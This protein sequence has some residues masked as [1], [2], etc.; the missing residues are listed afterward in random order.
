MQHWPGLRGALQEGKWQPGS[1]PGAA[2]M[3][4][5]SAAHRGIRG[6]GPCQWLHHAVSAAPGQK[7][8]CTGQEWTLLSAGKAMAGRAQ[9]HGRTW[10]QKSA[11]L[12]PAEDA[13]AW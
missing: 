8:W 2:G 9:T 11:C 3:E 6:C 7:R 4:W 5:G 1:V 12:L 13:R 10:G